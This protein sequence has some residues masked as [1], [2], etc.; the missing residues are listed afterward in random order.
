MNHLPFSP[1]ERTCDFCDTPAV[2]GVEIINHD[3]VGIGLFVYACGN[4]K[5]QATDAVHGRRK[6]LRK[7]RKQTSQL[8]D[9]GEYT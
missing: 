4:H 2:D 7:K 3:E 8:F 6:T 1:N 5:Q 9:L